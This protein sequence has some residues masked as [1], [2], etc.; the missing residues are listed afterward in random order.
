M[1]VPVNVSTELALAVSVYGFVAFGVNLILLTYVF[2]EI[3]TP[4]VFERAKVAVSV[5][6]LGTVIGVQLAA[7]FQSSEPG[8]RSHVALP[9]WVPRVQSIKINAPKIPVR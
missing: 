3:E 2:A 4:G 1:P 5:E 9:A 7:V 8:L 6:A